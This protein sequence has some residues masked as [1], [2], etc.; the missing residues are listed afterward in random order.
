MLELIHPILDQYV[1]EDRLFDHVV[2]R[3]QIKY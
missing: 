2:T 3:I 1:L